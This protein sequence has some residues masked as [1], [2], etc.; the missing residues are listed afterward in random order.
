MTNDQKKPV[1][2]VDGHSMIFQ[3]PD[4]AAHHL[5]N[6]V[7]ARAELVR[8]LDTLRDNSGRHVIVV[9]DGKGVRPNEAGDPGRVQI[10][11]S[12]AGQTADSIIVRWTP[13]FG[14]AVK[15]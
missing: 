7:A 6:P 13:K 5:R 11:Y 12:K 3:W 14:P 10:F 15:L 8:I 1:L 2:I 9:F 4:L